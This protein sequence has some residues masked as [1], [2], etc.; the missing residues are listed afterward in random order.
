MVIRERR[1]LYRL[2]KYSAQQRDKALNIHTLNDGAPSWKKK[3]E[4]LKR[5]MNSSTIVARDHNAH[6]WIT[7]Q[8]YTSMR[9]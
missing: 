5:E 3:G 4:E 7:E 8:L 9:K 2:I 6:L 1:A